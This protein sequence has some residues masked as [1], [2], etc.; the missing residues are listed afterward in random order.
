MLRQQSNGTCSIGQGNFGE[1]ISGHAIG[2]SNRNTLFR[3]NRMTMHVK[4]GRRY[5]TTKA[6]SCMAVCRCR[7]SHIAD[8][9]PLADGAITAPN[10]HQA[11]LTERAKITSRIND[12]SNRAS[13]D[14]RLD[15]KIN[16]I[17]LRYSAQVDQQGTVTSHG[18]ISLHLNISAVP[19]HVSKIN[20]RRPR[21]KA[22][23]DKPRRHRNVK[24]AAG[25]MV[26][27]RSIAQHD[28]RFLR[29]RYSRS[30]GRHTKPCEVA[31]HGMERHAIVDIC[32]MREGTLD[33]LQ[34][35]SASLD[36]YEGT[37]QRPAPTYRFSH[38]RERSYRCQATGARHRSHAWTIMSRRRCS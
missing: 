2:S 12:G 17:S 19:G 14:Q 13:G 36:R 20:A 8:F 10:T 4:V 34:I 21:K 18:P 27:H 9:N 5:R 25:F 35:T 38:G 23:R 7:Q 37:K 32:H 3:Q 30:P 11:G 16:G 24:Q 28:R 29:H 26:E 33:I 22:R 15:R 6:P 31:R 1:C